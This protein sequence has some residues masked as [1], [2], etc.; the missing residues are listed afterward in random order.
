MNQSYR[1]NGNNLT[2]IAC[3]IVNKKKL[4][5]CKPFGKSL[6]VFQF[7]YK[8]STDFKKIEVEFFFANC[9]NFN[10][11]SNPQYLLIKVKFSKKKYLPSLDKLT[12]SHDI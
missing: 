4:H 8:L 7:F 1:K 10:F 9:Q 11:F 6:K 5:P 12:F 3:V 2:K